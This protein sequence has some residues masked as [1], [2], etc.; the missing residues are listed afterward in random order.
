MGVTARPRGD[1]LQ[2]A[3]SLTGARHGAATG[4]SCPAGISAPL[5]LLVE[6]QLERK[7]CTGTR[8]AVG[9]DAAIV[10]LDHAFG[11]RETQ[12]GARS[13][14]ARGIRSAEG[15]VE[16]AGQVLGANSATGVGDA[17]RRGCWTA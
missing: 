14:L 17:D 7:S 5:A 2:G 8:R 6:R 3:D 1:R 15:A 10:E 13:V 9:G 16:H 4:R 11:D 12:P